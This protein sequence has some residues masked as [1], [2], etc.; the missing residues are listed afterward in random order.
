MASI[1]FA[2]CHFIRFILYH[3]PVFPANYKIDFISQNVLPFGLGVKIANL[4]DIHSSFIN[5]SNMCIVV[6]SV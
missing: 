1:V 5:L 4:I 6:M 2:S 3:D